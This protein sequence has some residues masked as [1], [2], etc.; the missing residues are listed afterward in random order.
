MS[1]IAPPGSE[2]IKG[3]ASAAMRTLRRSATVCACGKWE[4]EKAPVY[5]IID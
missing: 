2:S 4:M 3:I 5:H 1:R